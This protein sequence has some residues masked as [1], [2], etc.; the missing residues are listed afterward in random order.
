MN[1]RHPIWWNA[2]GT[3][4]GYALILVVMTLLLFGLPYL[5]VTLS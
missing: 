4:V 5:A 3:V 2:L 1:L